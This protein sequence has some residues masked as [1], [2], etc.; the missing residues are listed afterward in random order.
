MLF[1][2][3]GLK[4]WIMEK[5][6]NKRICQSMLIMLSFAPTSRRSKH[7]TGWFAKNP[8]VKLSSVWD[9]YVWDNYVWECM[10][11]K[12]MYE[13]QIFLNVPEKWSCAKVKEYI[14]LYS[15]FNIILVW[16]CINI[17]MWTSCFDE[18]VDRFDMNMWIRYVQ[19]LAFCKVRLK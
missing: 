14:P 15:C 7:L 9:N 11:G 16:E 3:H 1:I 12:T 10:R 8:F 2:I 19:L 4:T 18:S 5:Y 6:S 13:F 17:L